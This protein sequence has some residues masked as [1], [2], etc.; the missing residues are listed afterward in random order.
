MKRKLLHNVE[1]CP[2]TAEEVADMYLRADLAVTLE[3]YF[4]E[5]NLPDEEIGRLL[6]LTPNW[7]RD[8]MEGKA[9]KFSAEDLLVFCSKVGIIVE[10]MEPIQ[11]S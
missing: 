7:V 11:W 3:E 6:D 9:E 4:T 5:L 8:L 1:T 2:F 10:P